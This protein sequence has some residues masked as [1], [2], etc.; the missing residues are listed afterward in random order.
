LGV[1]A[2]K[3]EILGCLVTDSQTG[4]AI[5]RVK[6]VVFDSQGESITELLV[7]PL[8]KPQA[9]NDELEE[10]LVG[11][12]LFDPSERYLGEITDAL[13]GASSGA[14]KG[15]IT[16]RSPGQQS[17]IETPHGLLWGEEHWVLREEMPNL[18]H[19][20]FPAE[21]IEIVEATQA[22]DDWMVG[23]T[24]TVRLIDKRGLVIVEPG[25]RITPGI[26]EQASRA[27]VLHKLEAEFPVE[28]S[29]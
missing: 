10:R 21:P 1:N 17:L 8:A 18:R 14:L 22:A 16:E 15:V 3:R 28:G 9:T 13:V 25:Q 6:S 24:S 12:L 11:R 4:E 5:G 19:T 7:T 26:V 2:S 27:G 23:Q 20:M 29:A